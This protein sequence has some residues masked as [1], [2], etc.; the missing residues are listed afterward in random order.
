MPKGRWLCLAEINLCA[1]VLVRLRTVDAAPNFSSA[2][3]PC[4]R[5]NSLGALVLQLLREPAC[6]GLGVGVALVAQPDL[7]LLCVEERDETP[8]VHGHQEIK[9]PVVPWR[10]GGHLLKDV[11]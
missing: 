4:G 11:D 3:G 2:E 9:R 10:L 8:D 6:D 7:G 5:A 1:E